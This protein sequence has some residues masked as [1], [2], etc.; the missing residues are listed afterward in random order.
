MR[1]PL[2]ILVLA[3][4][5]GLFAQDPQLHASEVAAHR[6]AQ[7][8]LEHPVNEPVGYLAGL[9]A[10]APVVF[11]LDEDGQPKQSRQ[12]HGARNGL[13]PS[14][15]AVLLLLPAGSAR[16]PGRMLFANRGGRVFVGEKPPNATDRWQPTIATF[17]A[18]GVPAELNNMLLDSG[19]AQD[20]TRWTRLE[21]LE[22]T[23]PRE[24]RVRLV[25]VGQMTPPNALVEIAWG[26]RPWHP[27]WLPIGDLPVVSLRA[28]ALADGQPEQE[29]LA[30]G[31]GVPARGLRLHVSFPGQEVL[32]RPED[33]R[34]DGDELVV[35]VRAEALADTELLRDQ[36]WVATGL[37][38]LAEAELAFRSSHKVD[39]DGDGVGEFGDA[40]VVLARYAGDWKKLPSGYYLFRNHLVS[41]H[42]A[43]DADGAEQHFVAYAWP[44]ERRGANDLLFCVDERGVVQCCAADGRFAGEERT[45]AVDSVSRA[46]LGWRAILGQR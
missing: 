39:R 25:Q 46:D 5:G 15:T 6:Q 44:A 43:Q 24:Q 36:S 30:K 7:Q 26:P 32:L 3:S 22:T 37:R 40:E 12:L 14:A 13:D 4:A 33:V 16:N 8:W 35:S 45:P 27:A 29:R 31:P 2:P 28:Q 1:T 11:G 41:F 21:S 20:G 19:T 9:D 10:Y 23:T 42:L 17:A 18:P 38:M 34:M